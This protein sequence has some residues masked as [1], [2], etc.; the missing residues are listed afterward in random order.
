VFHLQSTVPMKNGN[1]DSLTLEPP[2]P[3][4]PVRT[5]AVKM[6]GDF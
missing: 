4:S 2:Y 5:V 1:F 3:E 6:I